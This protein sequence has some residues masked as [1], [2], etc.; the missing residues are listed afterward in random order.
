[1]TYWH[2]GF[3]N[4]GGEY[5]DHMVIKA[6]KVKQVTSRTLEV[7]GVTIYMSDDITSVSRCTKKAIWWEGAFY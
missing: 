2:V 3:E 6:K 5:G 4:N 1:M 7:D